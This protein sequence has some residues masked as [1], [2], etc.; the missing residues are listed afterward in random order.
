MG[1]RLSIVKV[2]GGSISTDCREPGQK[3]PTWPQNLALFSKTPRLSEIGQMR[4][5]HFQQK[6]HACFI[7]LTIKVRATIL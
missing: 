7:D 2:H 1:R 6:T 4:L 3:F 5:R